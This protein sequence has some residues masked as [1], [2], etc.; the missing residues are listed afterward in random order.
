MHHQLDRDA[1]GAGKIKVPLVVGWHCHNRPRAITH[2][3]IVGDPDRDPLLIDGIDGIG[4]RP[5]PGFL[6]IFGSAVDLTL[7]G[8]LLLVGGHGCRLGRRS[9]VRHQGMLGGQHHEGRPPQ[10]IGSRGKD[11][12]LITSLRLEDDLGSGG[13]A[14][15]VL[16]HHPHSLRPALQLV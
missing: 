10:G 9:Q 13:L 6:S 1:K 5:H 14:D 8:C 4:S 12:Q 11:G 3:H 2:K 15:P 16:L 7:A